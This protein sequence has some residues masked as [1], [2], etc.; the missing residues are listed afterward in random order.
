D[1]ERAQDE[2][3]VEKLFKDLT[4][5]MLRRKRGSGFD[6]SDS[7]SDGEARRRMKR[8]QFAKMQRAL[9]A[10]ERV[11][12]MAENQDPGNLAFLRSLEDRGGDGDGE[13]DML[14]YGAEEEEEGGSPPPGRGMQQQEEEE[15]EE[16][17]SDDD[18][19]DNDKQGAGRRTTIP[20][21]QSSRGAG[22]AEKRRRSTTTTTTTNNNKNKNKNKKKKK[23]KPCNV[24]HVRA[25]LSRLLDP[26]PHSF[27]RQAQNPAPRLR[28]SDRRRQESRARG[29]ERRIS[30]VGGLLARGAFE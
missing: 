10:D 28:E 26:E 5:G 1:R 29:A 3:Q 4:K 2:Q 18:D 19:D 7:D 20:D 21:S 27:A 11:K 30:L 9:F 14:L 6:L 13:L 24:G 17:E 22:V 8:R 15:E 12:K 23:K 16:E 25:T